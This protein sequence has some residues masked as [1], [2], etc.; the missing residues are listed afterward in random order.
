L[1]IRV[2]KR[3]EELTSANEALQNE[4][5]ERKRKEE[6]IQ[7]AH[8]ELDQIFKAAAPLCVIDSEFKMIRANDTFCS[9]LGLTSDDI[10]GKRCHD[11]WR[12]TA[13][14]TP[15]CPMRMILAGSERLGYE[16]EKELKDG[17]KISCIVKAMPYRDLDGEIIGIVENIRDVTEHKHLEAQFLHAQKMEAVGRLAGGIA[18]DFNNLLT[19]ISGNTELAMMSVDVNDPLQDELKQVQEA[20]IRASDLIRQL[21]AFGRKQVMELKSLNLNHIIENTH[22]ML[23]RIIGEDIELET[24]LARYL[25]RV[26][27]DPAQIE[28]VIVNLAVNAR[29]AMPRGGKLTIE[30]DKVE[31]D[32]SY[33]SIHPQIIPGKYA[34]MAI[35]DTGVGMTEEVRAKIFEPFFT[36]KETGR[37]TGLG[38]STVYGII[39]QSGGFIWVYSELGKG[40]A[41]KIYLPMVP[42]A[43]ETI[44]QENKSPDLP[45]GTEAILVVEDDDNVRQLTCRILERQ[46]YSVTQARTGMEAC[47]MCHEIKEPIDLVVTDVVMPGIN[48]AEL[49]ERIRIILPDVKVLFVSGYTSNVIVHNGILGTNTPYLQKPFNPNDL[50]KKV[51]G[52]LNLPN[53][54]SEI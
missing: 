19:V 4:I 34:M 16:A 17:R 51:Q 30:T 44:S 13:C 48:G 24:I 53:Q 46:G 10:I 31:L 39:K 20:A 42:E 5:D 6:E 37:G 32:E 12:G 47:S 22:K 33:T 14:E 23:R 29:D 49:M 52:V 21:L 8:Q 11:I 35:S 50:I 27:V 40:T 7:R 38:L 25:W 41:F 26:K 36:T 3:T 45:R 18:H 1:E 54:K 15:D 2:Q 43:A 28:Q 9:F